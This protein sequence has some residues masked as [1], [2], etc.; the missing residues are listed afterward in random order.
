MQPEV[1]V[2]GLV[3]EAL[4]AVTERLPVGTNLALLHLLWAQVS[5]ALLPS[6]GAI[7]PALQSIGLVASEI[8]RAWAALRYGAWQIATLLTAWREYVFSQGLWQEHTHAGYRP[9]AVDLTAYWR[10]KLRG[11]ATKH[12]HPAAKRALPAVVLG[13]AVRIGSVNGQRVALITDLVRS[14][15]DDASETALRQRVVRQVA[16]GLAADEMAIFDAGFKVRELQAVDLKQYLVRLPVNFTARRNELP[17]YKGR[18][19]KPRYG[20][21][22]RPLSRK[23]RTGNIIPATPPDRVERWSADGLELRAEFWDDL[24]LADVKVDSG[25][26]TF[27]AAAIH[28]SRFQKP[29]LLG[30]PL[31][32]SGQALLSLYRDRWPVEQVPLAGKQMLGGARQ[33]VFALESRQRLPE[34][35]L[36]AG[37]IVTYLAATM[38]AIPTGFW[39]RQPQAT[40][41]RLRRWLAQAHFP[42]SWPLTGRLRKKESPHSHLPKGIAAHRRT[43]QTAV[44]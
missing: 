10:P 8:R 4:S 6:R 3:M 36:L 12:Y 22:V 9:R 35:N 44:T 1:K 40:P 23:G 27:I 14:D 19:R 30:C 21:L 7:F 43:K 41:G 18:G 16:A 26:Q 24:V 33:F 13:I 42:K 2:I 29:L 34:L 38:P 17:S 28:D 25:N 39:D 32:L 5:G 20:K 37:S 11:L 15:P 31:H